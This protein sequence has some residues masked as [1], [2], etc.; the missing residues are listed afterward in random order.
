TATADVAV[1]RASGRW[2]TS[3]G[4]S[5]L[6]QSSDSR[7]IEPIIPDATTRGGGI[8]AIAGLDGA[9]V[10]LLLGLRGDARH[11]SSDPN[12]QLALIAG[13][14][15]NS[16]LTGD[17]GAAW[18]LTPNVSLT[19]NAGRAWRAPTLF[20]LY[21]NGPRPGEERFE[22]GN[23]NLDPETS[24]NVDAGIRWQSSRASGEVSLF[25]DKINRFIYIIPTGDTEDNLRVY[26]YLQD[27]ATLR[28]AEIAA[29]FRPIEALQ[30]RGRH[31]FVRGTNNALDQPL[32]L[33]PAQRTAVAADLHGERVGALRAPSIGIEVEHNASQS[34]RTDFDFATD[35]YTLLHLDAGLNAQLAGRE[36][37]IALRVRNLTDVAYK[38]YLSRYKE[39]A[40]DPGRNIL[41][42]IS[43]GF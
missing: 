31:D 37:R 20:E 15:N 25:N 17:L 26:R 22:I 32:P 8:F 2:H 36:Y 9:K 19:A 40:L 5:G 33:I 10:S 41:L 30:L 38:S 43:T 12:E 23:P 34:R 4:V 1:H 29:S 11:I 3:L 28:G 14:R 16:A 6:L 18:H 7:G 24:F 27:D 42:R 39:F 35:A 21:S 13:S